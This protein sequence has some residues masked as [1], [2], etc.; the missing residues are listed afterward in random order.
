MPIGF[1]KDLSWWRVKLIELTPI[2][3]AG[4]IFFLHFLSKM[5]PN[6]GPQRFL[7]DISPKPYPAQS[8]FRASLSCLPRMLGTSRGNCDTMRTHTSEQTA[9]PQL[10]HLPAENKHHPQG[11]SY[12]GFELVVPNSGRTTEW[13]NLQ[14]TL[15][16]MGH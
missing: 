7:N 15:F 8:V 2:N 6:L 4:C 11:L 13:W 16:I 1:T 3:T 9:I 10:L 14:E 5:A 12:Q